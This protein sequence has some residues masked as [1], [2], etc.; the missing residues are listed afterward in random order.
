MECHSNTGM[1]FQ[2]ADLDD[3]IPEDDK[4]PG[5]ANKRRCD[6]NY[7][8]PCGPCDGVGGPYW[9][10]DVSKFQPTNCEVVSMPEDVPE[11]ERMPPQFA[12]KFIVHQLGSDR[13]ARVQNAAGSH[14]FPPLYSQ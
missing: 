4:Y 9:G 13:F 8:P 14:F 1:R 10:D 12:E 7:D 3:K 5:F 6:Q 2:D 11:E